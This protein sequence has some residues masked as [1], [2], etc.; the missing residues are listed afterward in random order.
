MRRTMQTINVFTDDGKMEIVRTDAID[1]TIIESKSVRLGTKPRLHTMLGKAGEIISKMDRPSGT[2][3]LFMGSYPTKDGGFVRKSYGLDQFSVPT[4]LAFSLAGGEN[5]VEIHDAATAIAIA[6]WEAYGSGLADSPAEQLNWARKSRLLIVDADWN[7]VNIGLVNDGRV[8]EGLSRRY[9][10]VLDHKCAAK[11]MDADVNAYV[12]NFMRM[13]HQL[14]MEY[15]PDL[16]ILSFEHETADL[17]KVLKES[18]EWG[19]F[20]NLA[21][22]DDI[23]FNGI[24]LSP[25]AVAVSKGAALIRKKETFGWTPSE[26][27]K[28]SDDDVDDDGMMD[29]S[30]QIE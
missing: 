8:I 5:D 23:G 15:C 13:V 30:I 28:D 7:H 27:I 2:P 22:L 10:D 20:V 29:L 3:I 16:M 9:D 1:F 19:S 18:D 21:T 4:E 14:E 26:F 11:S 12:D 24:D 25:R 6:S 17:H